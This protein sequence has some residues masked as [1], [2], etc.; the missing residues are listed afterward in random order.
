MTIKKF[1]MFLAEH[2]ALGAYFAAF[3]KDCERLGTDEAKALN[4]L[5]LNSPQNW[6]ISA[7]Y[8]DETMQG[9]DYWVRLNDLWNESF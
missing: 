9:S 3:E 1:F 2:K 8:W 7:F 6:I 4:S 5:F